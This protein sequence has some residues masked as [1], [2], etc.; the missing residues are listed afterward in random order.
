MHNVDK[1]VLGN[2]FTYTNV[3]NQASTRT[4]QLGQTKVWPL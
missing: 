2:L 3:V 1:L 4:V